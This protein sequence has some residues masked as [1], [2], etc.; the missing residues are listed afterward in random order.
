MNDNPPA[1]RRAAFTPPSLKAIRQHLTEFASLVGDVLKVATL[2][3]I[4]LGL[5][6]IWSFA[7]KALIPFQVDSSSVFVLSIVAL[8][9][10]LFLTSVIFWVLVPIGI[11]RDHRLLFGVEEGTWQSLLR[12]LVR[13]ALISLPYLVWAFSWPLFV[14]VG[15]QLDPSLVSNPPFLGSLSFYGAAFLVSLILALAALFV[16]FQMSGGQFGVTDRRRVLE[17]MVS[18]ALTSFIWLWPPVALVG[19]AAIHMRIIA[20]DASSW[21]IVLIMFLFVVWQFASVGL[22]RKLGNFKATIGLAFLV[23]VIVFLFAPVN[24]GAVTLRLI[25][26]GGGLPISAVVKLFDESSGVQKTVHIK[27]CLVM[28]LGNQLSIQTPMDAQ[29]GINH[30]HFSPL[31]PIEEGVP[32]VVHTVARSDVIE[33]YTVGF[34]TKQ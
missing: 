3:S 24:L 5:L 20:P 19:L 33:I 4:G 22:A 13:Y 10:L 26:V 14:L 23:V 1:S 30:C 8:V 17:A 27:G 16:A 12:D 11:I 2:P 34:P 7:G 9:C 6:L 25:G 21:W 15:I 28:W 18:I 31:T 32:T 29:R